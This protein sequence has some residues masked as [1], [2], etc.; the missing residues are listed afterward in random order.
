MSFHNT[1]DKRFSRKPS[2]ALS[3]SFD[4]AGNRRGGRG[5]GDRGRGGGRGGGG[6]GGDRGRGG[7]YGGGGGGGDRGRGGGYGGG[8]GGGDRGRGGG[9]GGGGGGGYQKREPEPVVTFKDPNYPAGA[10]DA[11]FTKMED[12]Y[13]QSVSGINALSKMSL[14]QSY[15]A[16]PG[17]GTSGRPV[18]L[19]ANYFS[20]NTSPNLALGRYNVEI[21]PNMDATKKKRT[22]LFRLVLE[23]PEFANIPI[24]T[25]YASM[26]VTPN[27]LPFKDERIF[28]ITWRKEEED[29][30]LPNAQTYEVKIGS[31]TSI[32]I[33]D[34]VQFLSKGSV[35]GMPDVTKEEIT[36][37]MNTLMGHYAKSDNGTVS[38]AGNRHF[39]TARRGNENNFADLR[40]G[41]EAIRG[42]YQSVRPAT[43]RFLLNV[44]VTHSV[45]LQPGNLTQLFLSF[46]G[47]NP[48][49]FADKIKRKRVEITHLPVKKSKAG[50]IIPREKSIWDF[51]RPNDGRDEEHPP[52]VT[53][54]AAGPMDVQFWLSAEPPSTK[55]DAPSKSGSKRASGPAL[56]GNKYI[57]VY[58]YFKERYRGF[59]LNPKFPVVNVGSNVKPSYLP[60]EACIIKPGQVVKK[61]LLGDQTKLMLDFANRRPEPN[62]MSIITSGKQVLGL[63]A[64]DNPILSQFGVQVGNS[65]ITVQ[66]RVLPPPPIN[67]M[68]QNRRP[69]KTIPRDGSWNMRDTLFH[70]SGN[71]G[72]W[73]YVIFKCNGAFNPGPGIVANS[74]E[75]LKNHLISAGI[76]ARE[77]L[78][79]AP[80]ILYVRGNEA[81]T[82]A[83][84]GDAFRA[85]AKGSLKKKP[86]FLLCVLP[87][88]DVMLYNT[89]KRIG[90]IN[91][92]IHTVCVLWDNLKKE[93]P[94]FFGNV[95]LKFNLKA[96]GINQTVDKLGIISEGKTMVVGI[97]VTH[98][99]P[100]S[101][102]TAPSVA[103]MVANT[104]KLLGQWSG[105]CRLQSEA[106][107][108]VVS[109]I[110]RMFMHLLGTWYRANKNV[111]PENVLIY[112]DGVSEGQ[113]D[114]LL[115]QELPKIRHACRQKYPADYTKKNL[116]RISIVVCG[117]RHHTRF[118]PKDANVADKN[119]NCPAG[120]V[121][122]RGVTESRNWDFFLQPHQCLKGT[123]RPCHYFVIIDEIFKSQ[124]IKPPHQTSA[125]ALE[126]LTH[127]M[128]HLFGRATKAVSLCPPA[129]YA[130][131]LCTRMRSYL[132][133]HYDPPSENTTPTPGANPAL[134]VNQ[135]RVT[136]HREME[137]SMFW[138]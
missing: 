136:I 45:F 127:N 88:S 119:S 67:Y 15:P 31:P 96:G 41:L 77:T 55:G 39:S 133:D 52:R 124:K 42:F 48:H 75:K 64:K 3:M 71:L 137:T 53:G 37:V 23:L 86:K 36:Q 74:V 104:D 7:G 28:T 59:T 90:D 111:W 115:Q 65:L 107:Q 98:P 135:D 134:G 138:I 91:A 17:Y 123:A 44:N 108:E 34:F 32:N 99:S 12:E 26:L 114:I 85:L 63:N 43:G 54:F 11:K 35:T 113:Y 46:G 95:A 61:T 4:P 69:T 92:G 117:K 47:A 81:A 128:C 109:E 125:D 20:L 27:K 82:S 62:A 57:S 33:T 118:Y 56:K 132:A 110:E 129:Y 21:T 2:L 10:P 121:V 126:E 103:C 18:Q 40:M 72:P 102:D 80:S 131:L 16:R 22:Q 83:N 70:T 89:I 94:Q 19:Y 73:T 24:V 106:R 120:T 25:D 58:D 79:E 14:N 1:S 13:H 51:A 49:S 38:I 78:P 9:Y 66:G 93:S 105:I 101:K 130:D 8:G 6:G 112:R 97:D 116:P 50:T 87:V 122:D 5:G 60:M 76:G 84:V 68:N 100:G 30:P 29:E